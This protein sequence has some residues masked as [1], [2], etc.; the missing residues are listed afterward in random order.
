VEQHAGLGVLQVLQVQ[1][2]LARGFRMTVD[3]GRLP[4]FEST[5]ASAP[6]RSRLLVMVRRSWAMPTPAGGA[7]VSGLVRDDGGTPV[8]GAAVSLGRY[9]TTSDADGRYHF[10]HVPP[11]EHSL[12]IVAGHLPASYAVAGGP[13]RL[14]IAGRDVTADLPVT[15]LRAV[16]GR[17]FLD[18]SRNGRRDDREG[19]A[20]IVV[21]IDDSD[22][23]TITGRDGAFDFYNL[24][25][26]AHTIW[27]DRARLRADLDVLSP[28][29]RA[30]DLQP[31]RAVVDL[32]F[33]LVRRT[34]PI[35]MKE[36]P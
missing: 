6:D 7:D 8:A 15:A 12:S 16:H 20:G 19:A 25:P 31:D 29:R 36:L 18:A 35:L 9:L 28:D 30:I 23:A 4:A 2:Q 11:G 14:T 21:R 17:V 24:E 32:E 13:R 22:T 3:Y 34:K 1:Q 5:S 10:R 26:G 27:I 33:T